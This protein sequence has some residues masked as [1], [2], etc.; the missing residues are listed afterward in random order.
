MENFL[1]FDEVIELGCAPKVE[2]MELFQEIKEEV[3]VVG[4]FGGGHGDVP[5]LVEE[6]QQICAAS[7]SRK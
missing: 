5:I 6:G 2:Q 1:G 7:S 3:E 4:Q